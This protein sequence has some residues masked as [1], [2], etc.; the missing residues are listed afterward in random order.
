VDEYNAI[1]VELIDDVGIIRLN[2]PE[3][4]NAAT[5]DMFDEIRRATEDLRDSGARALLLTGVGKGF[6]SGADLGLKNFGDTS[7]GSTARKGLQSHYNPGMNALNALDIPVVC[8][9]NGPAAGIGCAL[10]LTGDII[11]AGKSAYFLQAFA[12]I[13]L[14]PDGGSTW[15]LPRLMS[16]PTALELMLTGDRLYAERAEQIGLINR[17]VD[18]ELLFDEA[19]GMA[20]RLATGPTVALGMIRQLVRGA[21]HMSLTEAMNLEAEAQK[22]AG[23]SEDFK[24]GIAAFKEKRKAKFQGR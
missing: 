5:P 21:Q 4:L 8:A 17:C 2:R 7:P 11:F 16:M 24:E 22:R 14:V 6:C 19:M 3:T 12:N 1:I 15:L 9:V 18:D 10:A 23:D 20:K 13:G